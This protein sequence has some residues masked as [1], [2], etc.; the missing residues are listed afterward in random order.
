MPDVPSHHLQIGQ[1]LRYPKLHADGAPPT[2]VDG[3]VNFYAATA[4]SSNKALR[5]EAGINQPA[6]VAAPD[7][8]RVAVLALATSPNKVGRDSTP[9]QDIYDTDNGYV[10]Y[11]GDNRSPGVDPATTLGNRRLLAQFDLHHAPSVEERMRAA[12]ITFFRR[13]PQQAEPKD[14]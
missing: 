4:S 1:I 9:W 5:L 11:F 13:V 10:R 12:P 7:G 6:A 14:S 3:L 2:T 8:S